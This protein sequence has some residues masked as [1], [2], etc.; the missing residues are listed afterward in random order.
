MIAYKTHNFLVRRLIRLERRNSPKPG[1]GKQG[2]TERQDLGE[3]LSV[4]RFP[5]SAQTISL[6]VERKFPA[7]SCREFGA[8]PIEFCGLITLFQSAGSLDFAKFPV[9]FPVAVGQPRTVVAK[10]YGIL[11]Q[12]GGAMAA[13]REHAA[14]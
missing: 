10:I 8:E 7:L 11:S 12:L 3:S 6:I 9:D 13:A 2:A 5:C 1:N 4:S 14:P